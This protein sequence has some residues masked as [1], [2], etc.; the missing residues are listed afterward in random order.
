MRL[1]GKHTLRQRS[2]HGLI[3]E[4]QPH[5]YIDAIVLREGY[6]E[7]EVID[8][9]RPF[10]RPGAVFWDVGANIGL[11]TVTAACLAPGSQVVAFEPN[12]AVFARLANPPPPA[13][14]VS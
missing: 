1:A 9:L 10:L 5:E 7:P 2:L 3:F 4:L 11:H 6:Y 14:P 13:N 8:A 12:P